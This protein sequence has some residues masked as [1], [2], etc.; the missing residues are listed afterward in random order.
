LYVYSLADGAITRLSDEH[1]QAYDIHWSG[2]SR[3]I[4]YFSASCFG[5]GAGFIMEGVWAYRFNDSRRIKLYK[6]SDESYAEEFI[7]W[8]FNE[9]NAFYV[10][11]R[12][13][14]PLR[15]LRLVD[16]DTQNVISIYEGCFEDVAV[17]PTGM[18]AVLTSRDFSDQPGLYLYT[19]LPTIM[20][21]AYVPQENGRNIVSVDNLL[22]VK[23]NMPSGEEIR[24]FD[25][26]GKPGRYQGKGDF[27]TFSPDGNTWVWNE[28]GGFYFSGINIG[29]PVTLSDQ[30]VQHLLWYEDV[31][32]A[33]TIHQRLLFFDNS[34]NLYQASDPDYLP[35]LLADN[36]K[37]LSSPIKIFR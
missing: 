14:C 16:L 6:P 34:G 11:T 12:S 8:L 27:P 19:E 29:A 37:P 3:N 4:V 23:S 22:I 13:G 15:D 17:G 18:L 20:Q 5:T 31:S 7:A 36:L 24:S 26:S 1:A 25:W 2:D 28:N 10:A 9:N 30:K 32:Q 35:V 33:G 21:P